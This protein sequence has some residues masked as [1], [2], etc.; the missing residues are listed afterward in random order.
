[1][2]GALKR[3]GRS[4]AQMP[5]RLRSRA[6]RGLIIFVYTT[7]CMVLM[8]TVLSLQQQREDRRNVKFERQIAENCLLT[9][10]SNRKFNAVLD[11]LTK[12]AQR[13]TSL[14][15]AQKTQAVEVYSK[16]HLRINTC[17]PPR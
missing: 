9:N 6:S 15:P 4:L 3:F 7:T 10:D 13:S 11:Q 17:P 16:L 5:G 2:T 8:F 1:M 12:N 14:K